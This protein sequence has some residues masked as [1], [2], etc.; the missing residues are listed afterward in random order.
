MGLLAGA[1]VLFVTAA[2]FWACLPR[3]GKMHRWVGTEFEPYV[4]VAICS[5][6][7]LGFSLVLSSVLTWG[8]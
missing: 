5:G 2:V 7:A 1:G 8:S 3:G 4:A 6:V